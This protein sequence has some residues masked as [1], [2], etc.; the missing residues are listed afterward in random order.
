MNQEH[1]VFAVDKLMAETR[2]L[3]ANYYKTTQQTLPITSELARFDA[4]SLLGLK[5]P[6]SPIAGV[7]ALTLTDE[8]IQ[9]KG[10]VIFDEGKGGYRIGQLNMDGKW[11]IVLLVLMNQDYETTEIY[12]AT[13]QEII[14]T[15][16]DKNN[17]KR[18]KRGPMSVAKFKAIGRLVWEENH[19]G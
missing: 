3:A 13:R 2:R 17:E 7:D 4:M 8:N 10:R 14:E 9:I 11:H 15:L 5:E 12:E 16:E 19:H 18:T 6:P 1:Q